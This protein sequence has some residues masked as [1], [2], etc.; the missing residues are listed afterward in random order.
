[1]KTKIDDTGELETLLG[2]LEPAIVRGQFRAGCRRLEEYLERILERDG[3][4]AGRALIE[5]IHLI[6]GDRRT[7]T[8]SVEVNRRRS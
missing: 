5:R 1:M 7:V 8:L 3:P 4:Q 6:A 2:N